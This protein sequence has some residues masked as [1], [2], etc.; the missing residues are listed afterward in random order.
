MSFYNSNSDLDNF[1][2]EFATTGTLDPGA[3]NETDIDVIFDDA[4]EVMNLQTGEVLN[5]RPQATC[6]TGDVS[7]IIARTTKI[8]INSV[9][10]E[11]NNVIDDGTGI[12][13]LVLSEN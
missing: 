12:S 1:F 8:K 3:T 4:Q 9:T 6:R 2:Q 13:I 11:I 7:S 10:Y 5:A